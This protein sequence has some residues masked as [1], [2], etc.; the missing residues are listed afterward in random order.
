MHMPMQCARSAFEPCMAVGPLVV[1]ELLSANS[2]ASYQWY[3][4]KHTLTTHTRF[5]SP[6]STPSCIKVRVDWVRVVNGNVHQGGLTRL[7]Q[8][9]RCKPH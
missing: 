2:T 1:L 7:C 4:T 3:D 8:K 9:P 6:S 5:V